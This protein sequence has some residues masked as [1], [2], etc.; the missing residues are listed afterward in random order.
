M[1]NEESEHCRKM[2]D[3][4]REILGMAPL[5]APD[6]TTLCYLQQQHFT[7]GNKQAVSPKQ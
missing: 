4:I 5:Y 6:T 3:A 1:K 2:V 7:D